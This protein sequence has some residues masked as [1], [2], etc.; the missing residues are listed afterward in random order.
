M[1][2]RRPFVN[3]L[4]Q[5][6]PPDEEAVT[7][8]DETLEE[9]KL[10]RDKRIRVAR[11]QG[12]LS[13]LAF[14]A[15][16]LGAPTLLLIRLTP[17]FVI[18]QLRCRATDRL[19]PDST[20][21]RLEEGYTRFFHDP[22]LY[23][24]ESYSRAVFWGTY[25][26]S[27]IFAM[28]SRSEQPITVGIAWYD[29]KREHPLRHI[30]PFV[31]N[32]VNAPRS[33]EKTGRDPE[34][35]QI[36][37]LVHD[38][39]H[40]G[41][42][43]IDDAA[44]R[45]S[46]EIE[47]LK[48]PTGDSWHVRM[49]GSLTSPDPLTVV[50][51]VMNGDDAEPILVEEPPSLPDGRS[52]GDWS[53]VLR[54]R[55]R[56]HADRTEA[57]SVRVLS[58]QRSLSGSAPWH[59]Y[60]LQTPADDAFALRAN[61]VPGATLEERAAAGGGGVV[62]SPFEAAE[63]RRQK[64]DLRDLPPSAF[65]YISSHDKSTFRAPTA[66]GGAEAPLH[67]LIVLKKAYDT[68]FRL[69]LS[70]SP[71]GG[72]VGGGDADEAAAAAAAAATPHHPHAPLAALSSCQLA[73]TLR[74][75]EKAVYAHAKRIFRPMTHKRFNV[76]GAL[77]EN[78]AAQTLAETLASLSF[79]KGR[80]EVV[81]DPAVDASWDE[82]GRAVALWSADLI[83]PSSHVASALSAIGSRTDEAFGQQFLSGLQLLFLGRWNKELVKD[84]IASWL[85]G[86]QDP[87]T[88]FLPSRAAFTR[89]VRSLTP[90]SLRAEHPTVSAAPA[91]VLGLQELLNE[92]ERK[93][94]RTASRQRRTTKKKTVKARNTAAYLER[95]QS[96]D[97]AFLQLILPSLKRWRDWWHLTQ[98]GALGSE[99]LARTCGNPGSQRRP[100]EEWP[101]RPTGDPRDQLAYRWRS[102][103][104]H[105]LF[106]SG[107]EDYPRPVC[108]G[109]HRLEAHVDLFSW[110]ALLSNTISRIEVGH[111]GLA[112]AS[113]MVDWEAHLN[114]LHWDAERGRYADRVGC[115]SQ[116]F[117]PYTGYANLY[118]VML[119]IVRA[120][121]AKAEATIKLARRELM[122]KYGLMS[123]SYDSVRL[124]RESR[125]PHSNLWMGLVW[126]S[127]NLLFLHAIRSTYIDL[128]EGWG[129]AG[130]EALSGGQLALLY[131]QLRV[132]QAETIRGGRRWWEGFNP[133]NGRGE[134]SKTHIGTRALI[135]GSLYDFS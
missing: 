6:Q 66:A 88:G 118:P 100:L 122:T 47:F 95:E 62:T 113:V 105:R 2:D 5:Q 83:Q 11:R 77:Y 52:D 121:L 45:A 56:N 101:V 92:M 111:L 57:F 80:Y 24:S 104:G 27:R 43:S 73:N 84:T 39:F 21:S 69:E 42:Q 55:L 12:Y 123:V 128:F 60:G 37:W 25:E 89:T 125:L 68:D 110:V 34:V 44:N 112:K 67:N 41:R 96:A 81:S 53:P 17:F 103:D 117:S 82:K 91:L 29:E 49:Q 106:A 131:E 115:Q 13:Y 31:H 54:S 124:A 134:G 64:V 79:T 58:T 10:R 36:R 132:A 129:S 46:F 63:Q 33:A 3:R 78:L 35:M 1:R 32:K 133:V 72:S 48:D 108:E 51:Y 38:G 99:E 14:L 30:M 87:V 86:A 109:E 74:R 119:G 40:Y 97:R 98:C 85:V 8:P 127:A 26:P 28:K 70:L 90:P 102:R 19:H 107:M 75:R 116:A 20:V 22:P 23:P 59:V 130:E 76:S 114:A 93:P 9:R 50:V 120:D 4:R 65:P 94:G 15:I 7:M 135:L 61:E 16:F 71:A 18:E 126:P